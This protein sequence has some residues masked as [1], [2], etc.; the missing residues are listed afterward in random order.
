MSA[1]IQVENLSIEFVKYLGGEPS[2][3]ADM[4][5]ILKGCGQKNRKIKFRA[6][7]GINLDL[8]NGDRLGIIGRNGAGKSTLMKAVAGIYAPATGTV[9]L[10][11]KLV[12]L[13]ELGTG[14]DQFSSV[15][16]NIY[17]NGAILNI[18]KEKIAEL[19]PMILNFSELEEF[20]DQPLSGL[21]SGMRSRLSFSIASFLEPDILL[22]DEVFAA[23]DKSFVKKA[24]LRMLEIIETSK[25]VMF[26]SHQES[27]ILN[28]CNKAIVLEKGEIIFSGD[29]GSAINYYNNNIV[30]SK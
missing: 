9:R 21:S 23:G 30:S 4:I 26:S 6:I 14:F 12:P 3:K 8:A 13:L 24:R 5:S 28:V 10:K 18:P 2:L 22:L 15:R 16:Q 25:I 7:S 11:G 20:K 19:E 27:L 1:F 17:L 29:P